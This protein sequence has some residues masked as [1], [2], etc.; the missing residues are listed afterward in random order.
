MPEAAEVAIAEFPV[1]AHK[2]F[3]SSQPQGNDSFTRAGT[4]GVL[5]AGLAALLLFMM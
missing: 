4:L 1:T 2:W 3:E 5:A